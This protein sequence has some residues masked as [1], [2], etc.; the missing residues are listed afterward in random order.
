VFH[1]AIQK[2]NSGIFFYGLRTVNFMYRIIS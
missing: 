1:K 2:N